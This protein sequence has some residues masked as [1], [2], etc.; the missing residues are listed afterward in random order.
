MQPSYSVPC[1]G[2]ESVIQWLND[3]RASAGDEQKHTWT[4]NDSAIDVS[5]T[6][7]S[8]SNSPISS[9]PPPTPPPSLAT[10]F[11]PSEEAHTQI[12]YGEEDSWTDPDSAAEVRSRHSRIFHTL[13]SRR[14][15]SQDART[16]GVQAPEEQAREKAEADRVWRLKMD[17]LLRQ[18]RREP[19]YTDLR[20]QEF[21]WA[22]HFH[23]DD[24][25]RLAV[26]K[27]V[28]RAAHRAAIRENPYKYGA[29]RCHWHKSK[30]P[31]RPRPKKRAV[32]SEVEN[33]NKPPLPTIKVTDPEGE[34]WYL[35]DLF[36][37][38]DDD[39][40][41]GVSDEEDD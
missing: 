1:N 15:P 40:W 26:T 35:E 8:S 21:R 10:A 29:K 12:P 4:D 7:D 18:S 19:S 9:A 38:M 36:Y 5:S 17:R 31:P 39:G 30:K 23:V 41:D 25:G 37:Y 28:E 24:G 32:G 3:C 16:T 11:T 14:P 34:E 2:Y 27:E 22:D 20:L 33:E 13:P 6:W